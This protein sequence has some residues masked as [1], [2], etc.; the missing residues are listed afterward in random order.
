MHFVGFFM[1]E[2]CECRD[3]EDQLAPLT[4][5]LLA[6]GWVDLKSE[7]TDFGMKKKKNCEALPQLQSLILRRKFWCAF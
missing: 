6:I 2:K 1:N 4:L 5:S 3:F 7:Y